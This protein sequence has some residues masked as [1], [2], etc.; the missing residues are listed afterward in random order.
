MKSCD[1]CKIGAR[2]K[3]RDYLEEKYFEAFNFYFAKPINEIIAQIPHASHVIYFKDY[4]ILDERM[5][6][7]KRFYSNE[8]V[9]PRMDI[10]I[11]FYTQNYKHMHPNLCVTDA[12]KIMNKRNNRYDKLFYQKD[13]E[14]SH[15]QGMSRQVLNSKSTDNISFETQEHDIYE[16]ATQEISKQGFDLRGLQ[17]IRNLQQLNQSEQSDIT[18]KDCIVQVNQ[19]YGKRKKQSTYSKSI[20]QRKQAE[21][22]KKGITKSIIGTNSKSESKISSNIK[23]NNEEPLELGK[24]IDQFNDFDA[25]PKLTRMQSD[26]QTIQRMLKEYQKMKQLRSAVSSDQLPMSTSVQGFQGQQKSLRQDHNN[27][28]GSMHSSTSTK[29]E[30]LKKVYQPLPKK[31]TTNQIDKIAKGGCLTDRTY[32]RPPPIS[33]DLM[34]KIHDQIKGLNTVES[35]QK[36]EFKYMIPSQYNSQQN[37]KLVSTKAKSSNSKKIISELGTKSQHINKQTTQK[38]DEIVKKY[39]QFAQQ[40]MKKKFDFKLNLQGLNEEPQEEEISSKRN[41]FFTERHSQVQDREQFNSHRKILQK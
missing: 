5:E 27:N 24:G 11:D 6:Y 15:Q 13:R 32:K 3:M 23:Q 8:E 1:L 17:I 34:L 30:A 4:V 25:K 38:A 33:E 21:S 41:N 2:R 14:Q 39:I 29:Q 9:G 40:T 22:C 10:L 19:M 16:E 35:K 26:S 12:H 36:V 31:I 28:N 37:Q 20:K 18:L 7:L